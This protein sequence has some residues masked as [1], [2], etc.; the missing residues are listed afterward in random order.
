MDPFNGLW[1]GIPTRR[2]LGASTGYQR[3]TFPLQLIA[4]YLN[5]AILIQA[6]TG[7][8]TIGFLEESD[9]LPTWPAP[10]SSQSHLLP[11]LHNIVSWPFRCSGWLGFCSSGLQ[12]PLLLMPLKLEE[13]WGADRNWPISVRYYGLGRITHT[14]GSTQLRPNSQPEMLSIFLIACNILDE[15]NLPCLAQDWIVGGAGKKHAEP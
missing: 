3:S 6:E 14:S 5:P 13:E 11:I 2:E 15:R 9:H 10:P 8:A 7:V 12:Y 1:Q 4:L